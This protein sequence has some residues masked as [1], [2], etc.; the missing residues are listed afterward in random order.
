MSANQSP[1][2]ASRPETSRAE[3][4]RAQ[5][6]ETAERLF[7]SMGYQ[8]TAVADI[9]RELGMS[10]ANVYRFFPSKAAINEA[11]CARVVGLL[12]ARAWV[13]ARGPGTPADRFRAVFRAMQQMTLE[14]AFQERRMIEMLAVAMEEHWGV[15]KEHV[16]DIDNAVRHI[17]MDGQADGSFARLDPDATG[18]LIHATMIGFCH[19][20][21]VQ[22]CMEDDL[23]AMAAGMAEF[24]LRALRPDG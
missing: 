4:T 19:P 8:K 17:V 15:I 24:C 3:A 14:I 23:E 13:V 9:A 2:D 16:R 12:S 21:L 1:R 5:I 6:V 22:Q 20:T 7:R 18:R 10:P 11:I